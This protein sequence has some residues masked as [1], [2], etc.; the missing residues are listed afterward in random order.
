MTKREVGRIIRWFARNVGLQGWEI[1]VRPGTQS[2][3]GDEFGG[4]VTDVAYRVANIWN[5]NDAHKK[6]SNEMGDWQHTLMHELIHAF[7]DECGIKA[8]GDPAEWGINQL[9]SVLLKQYQ[10]ETK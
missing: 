10:A 9:A 8:K 5:N 7:F 4:C 2:G 3:K 1:V 6:Y